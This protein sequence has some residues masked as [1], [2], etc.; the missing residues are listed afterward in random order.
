[1][2]AE[3]QFEEEY[4]PFVG[5]QPATDPL[6]AL[7][8]A[9]RVVAPELTSLLS[10]EPRPPMENFP[11][12]PGKIPSAEDPRLPGAAV[13]LTGLLPQPGAGLSLGGKAIAAAVPR[14]VSAL[15]KTFQAIAHDPMAAVE[16]GRISTRLP[17][18]LT[19]GSTIESALTFP[20]LSVGIHAMDE[21]QLRTA[22][23][24]IKTYSALPPELRKGTHEEVISNYIE[25]V[26]QNLLWLHDH[27]QVAPWRDRGKLWYVG[28]RTISD[29]LAERIGV[30]PTQSAGALAALSPKTD[31]FQNVG[32]TFRLA[33]VHHELGNKPFSDAML[34]EGERFY[35]K[36]DQRLLLAA[37]KGKPY[38]ELELPGMRAAWFRL[39]ERMHMSQEFPI[40][41]PEGYASGLVM[42]GGKHPRPALI[43]TQSDENVGKAIA[44]LE[45]TGDPAEITY[46]LGARHKVRNFY[47]N[48]IAP[49]SQAGDVTMDTHAIAAALLQP[50]G[51]KDRE[52]LHNFGPA[53][54]S[55]ETGSMG[56]YGI[57][58]EAYRQAAAERGLLPREMQ[59]ITWEAVR[60]LFPDVIKTEQFK[61][62][63]KGIWRQYQEGVLSADDARAEIARRSGGITQ[64]DWVGR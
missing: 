58:A 9:G 10:G 59:S 41:R 50:F 38:N 47:N 18:A 33:Q 62:E 43:G 11:A 5:P 45:G 48:L 46:I 64:P 30:Q 25:H 42:T 63:I 55:R 49:F 21:G 37:I 52:V 20:R 44:M 60:G 57:Y 2:M 24:Y 1:M 32:M 22:A 3:P 29:H 28:G 61:R 56:L 31:W 34:Y 6:R 12:I 17:S 27:P 14:A 36:P 4:L 53:P 15:G 54:S 8:G 51:L 40:I 7:Q 19:G 23:Q 35:T 26:K 13:E 39:Y 16:A